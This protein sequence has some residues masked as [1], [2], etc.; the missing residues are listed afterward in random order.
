MRH[1]LSGAQFF[2]ESCFNSRSALARDVI[3]AVEPLHDINHPGIE[4]VECLI[5]L[6][7]AL[8]KNGIVKDQLLLTHLVRMRSNAVV[9]PRVSSDCLRAAMIPGL[10]I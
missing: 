3:E 7:V 2:I 5:H 8:S 6:T 4:P 1:A 9:F 10:D